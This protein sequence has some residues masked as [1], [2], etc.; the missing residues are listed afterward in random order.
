L[1]EAMR[2]LLRQRASDAFDVVVLAEERLVPA[3]QF[4]KPR[5]P[6]CHARRFRVLEQPVHLSE[7]FTVRAVVCGSLRAS[8]HPC[9]CLLQG[10]KFIGFPVEGLPAADLLEPRQQ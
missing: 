6:H 10:G 3:A 9:A 4:G 7:D 2:V 8:F 5:R 1:L